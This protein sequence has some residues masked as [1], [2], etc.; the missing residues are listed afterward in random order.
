MF[1]HSNHNKA[2]HYTTSCISIDL[3]KPFVF[4]N[5]K[6][7]RLKLKEGSLC[8]YNCSNR[9]YWAILVIPFH[10]AQVRD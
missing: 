10:S 6:L 5:F 8:H 2:T 1:A 3:D 4:V 7:R 9:C